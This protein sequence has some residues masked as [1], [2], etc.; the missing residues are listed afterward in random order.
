DFY[1]IN[2]PTDA[3]KQLLVTGFL[4]ANNAQANVSTQGFGVNN[5]S[6]N[7]TE[8]LQTDFVTGAARLAATLA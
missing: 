6:I 8:T 4:G 2:S 5:Q 1:L 3:S 7:P